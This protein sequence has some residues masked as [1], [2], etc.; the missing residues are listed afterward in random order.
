MDDI[1]IASKV[2]EA[3]DQNIILTLNFLVDQGYKSINFQP[4][5]RYIKF[6]LSKGQTDFYCK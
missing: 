3:P 1:L 2:K 5:L 4:I 6:E